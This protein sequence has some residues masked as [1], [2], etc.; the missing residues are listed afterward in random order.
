MKFPH[1]RFEQ[2][3]LQELAFDGEFD[4]AMC[5]DAMEHVPP[6]DWPR[7]LENLARAVPPGEHVYLTL[8]QIDRREVEEAFTDATAAGLPV[9]LGEVIAGDT[10]GYHYYADSDRVSGW[11]A[12]AGLQVVDEEDEWLDG[13]GYRH[14]FLRTS[15]S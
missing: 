9:V 3:G 2:V 13:Y 6:E 7:V 4:A 5:L 8:E 10:G 14:L 12:D 15:I 11:L 1:V